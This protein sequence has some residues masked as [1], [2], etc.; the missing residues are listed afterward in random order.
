MP[1]Y[2]ALDGCIENFSSDRCSGNIPLVLTGKISRTRSGVLPAELSTLL[3]NPKFN[4]ISNNFKSKA[5]EHC[6]PLQ[7]KRFHD[8]VKASKNTGPETKV[9][10][11]PKE[12]AHCFGRDRQGESQRY[13]YFW[14]FTGH[15]M[16]GSVE[17]ASIGT[18]PNPLCTLHAYPLDGLYWAQLGFFPAVNAGKILSQFP[19]ISLKL[20][21]NLRSEN[22][23]VPIALEDV[24]LTTPFKYTLQAQLKIAEFGEKLK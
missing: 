21:S 14:L 2:T 19:Q 24:R 23:V 15:K 13:E 6:G 3:P 16:V 18:V 7:I 1:E 12:L 10:L 17:C 8:W 5:V 9:S 22:G 4:Y 20:L 11:L